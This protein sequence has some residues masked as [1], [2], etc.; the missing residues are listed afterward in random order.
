[1]KNV[2]IISNKEKS[3]KNEV[4]K[5][6]WSAR[7]ELAGAF[8]ICVSRGWNETTAN[9]MTARVPDQPNYFL[10]NASDC[11]WA[12]VTASNLLKLDL[13][14]KVVGNT[15]RRPRPA[16]LN[17]HSAIQR[18]MPKINCSLHLH[19]I[20]GVVISAIQEGLMFFDQGSC[21]LY[22]SVSYH[23]FEGIAEEEDEA[24]RILSDLG[25]NYAMI[26]YNHGLLTVGRTVPEAVAYMQSLIDTCDKQ[27]R[28][29]SM[30]ATP[31][32]LSAELCQWTK[33]Q[34]ANRS[35]N[36][37]IGETE[38]L[39]AFRREIRQDPSFMD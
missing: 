23:E 28:I 32:P 38:F 8:R 12:E 29:L 17:F 19:P 13:N 1:M 39:A 2:S 6:E 16:G 37:P 36:Q 14:G 10:M 31:K 11:S 27:Y 3:L 21:S 9:H 20:A 4:S 30:N 18:E 24:P 25:E 33:S 7:V 35:N 22:G 15:E 34:M 26:M 5:T